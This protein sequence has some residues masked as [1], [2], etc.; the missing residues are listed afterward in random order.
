MHSC[1]KIDL[2]Y[3]C[4]LQQS[5]WFGSLPVDFQHSLLSC[6]RL[7]K[8]AA[9]QYLFYRDDCFDG[10]YCVLE[11][12]LRINSHNEQ[13]KEALLAVI[14][15]YNWFG[16]IALIDGLPRTHDAVAEKP[17]QLLWIAPIEIEQLLQQNPV[18]WRY[19]AQLSTQKIRFTF[20]NLEETALFPAF[21]RLVNRLI[22][23]AE[24]YGT[25]SQNSR[26]VLNLPQEQLASMLAISRQTT[27]QILKQLEMQQLIRVDYREVEILDLE[28]LKQLSQKI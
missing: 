28:A 20:T 15:P 18:Y 6:A 24:G 21:K 16:E 12:A 22:L 23:I 4:Q 14:E 27:N 9:Q 17:S 13:G 3:L 26:R 8:L 25:L 10:L 1:D 2:H 19:M 5:Q 7:K 11:G